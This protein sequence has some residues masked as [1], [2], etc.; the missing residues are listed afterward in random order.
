MDVIKFITAGNVD[1]GKST[2]IGRLL[3]DTHQIKQDII[4]SVSNNHATEINLAHITDG[5]REERAQGITVDVAYKY[6]TTPTRKFILT[7][8][9]GHFQYTRN[10][11]SGASGA[12]IMII[13]IDVEQG[14]TEQTKRH[15]Q[16]ASF[17]SIPQVMVA[18]NKMDMVEYNAS[19]FEKIKQEFESVQQQLRLNQ[20]YFIPIS[21]LFADNVNERSANI[22][23]YTGKTL[24]Q[25][26]QEYSP[27]TPLSNCSVCSVQ[28]VISTQHGKLGFGKILAGTFF[29][30]LP[31]TLYPDGIET[32]LAELGVGYQPVKEAHAGEVIRFYVPED[33]PLKRGQLLTNSNNHLSAKTEFELE[34]CWLD[35]KSPLRL[36]KEY[37]L[38]VHCA[39]TRCT[40]V[41]IHRKTNISVHNAE[42]DGSVIEQNEFARVACQT[43]DRI[44]Y[45]PTYSIA[46]L[47]R[48]ILIDPLT[49][50]T[51]AAIRF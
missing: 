50:Y 6:L 17:L 36:D 47:S 24:L 7:D 28:H 39:E 12:D 21:A 43:A 35:D 45:D 19:S 44:S 27:P 16:V 1:D 26:L 4:A 20:I 37:I 2:L 29:N 38:R 22:P 15:A 25:F 9:P 46:A 30:A 3:H 33:T 40:I 49:N 41:H 31:Y 5:L 11:I 13:L 42:G 23:W 18:V 48:G 8:A 51:C 14:I 32:T 34:V 10:L